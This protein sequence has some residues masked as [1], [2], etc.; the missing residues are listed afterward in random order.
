MNASHLVLQPTLPVRAEPQ[1]AGEGR[2]GPLLIDQDEGTLFALTCAQ[3]LPANSQLVIAKGPFAGIRISEGARIVGLNNSDEVQDSHELIAAVPLRQ[4][5]IGLDAY[6]MVKGGEPGSEGYGEPRGVENGTRWLGHLLYVDLGQGE[7]RRAKVVSADSQFAMPNPLTDKLTTF[8]NALELA[9]TDDGPLIQ[10]G[11]VG[12]LVMT[13]R[14]DWI[15][16]IVAGRHDV[17]YAAPVEPIIS[18]LG[19][20]IIGVA[21]IEAHNR[22]FETGRRDEETRD[23]LTENTTQRSEAARKAIV[24]ADRML[25]V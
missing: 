11:E 20:S 13:S 10:P 19:L 23:R 21:E 24:E 6:P 14:G 22:Q 5:Q 3:L 9:P 2:L 17:A 1:G 15:A 8:D 4:L 18:R 25:T 7:R 16:I 12:S